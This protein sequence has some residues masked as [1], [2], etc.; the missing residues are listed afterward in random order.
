[1]SI[2]FSYC[3]CQKRRYVDDAFTYQCARHGEEKCDM[4]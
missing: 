1:M 3:K 4:Q 2:L